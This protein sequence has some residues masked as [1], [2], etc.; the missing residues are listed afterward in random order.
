MG[1][2]RHMA[3]RPRRRRWPVLVACVLAVALAGGVLLAMRMQASG[4][5]NKADEMPSEAADVRRDQ[6]QPNATAEQRP[7]PQSVQPRKTELATLLAEGRV[8]SIRLVGDSIT[9]GYGTDGYVDPDLAGEGD[10]I[11][12]DGEGTV[13]RET[14]SEAQSWANEFRSYAS[15]HG[16]SRF[17]NAGINGAFM[18]GL[19]ERPQAWL[20]E[21]ADVI[22]VALG[23]NDAG[24]YG[25]EEYRD[26]SERAL[27]AAAD[28]CKILVVVS[29]VSDLRPEPMLV[30][31][32]GSLGDILHQICE[33]RGYLF[34]D[35]RDAVAPEQFSEDGLHP[36]TDGSLA[37]WA[38]ICD[39]LDL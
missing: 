12:D 3:Q 38:C 8:D 19:A 29:P 1:G 27:A 4:N 23:T 13:H 24:Y 5:G 33:A 15:E 20:G 30:E 7:D 9:A 17:V 34:V 2:A 21:G 14:S 28:A 37:I 26:A 32:A 36:T 10:V 6:G 35:A 22:F 18:A 39:T 25:P 16:V 31:P 11:Y